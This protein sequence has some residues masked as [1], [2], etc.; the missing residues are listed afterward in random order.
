MGREDVGRCMNASALAALTSAVVECEYDRSFMRI[1]ACALFCACIMLAMLLP[2]L[3]RRWTRASSRGRFRGLSMC[4]AGWLGPAE[5]GGRGCQRT[6]ISCHG[7][8]GEGG[9]YRAD[10]DGLREGAMGDV[11]GGGIIAASLWAGEVGYGSTRMG[12]SLEDEGRRSAN[13]D[14]DAVG[15]ADKVMGDRGASMC[16][17]TG[18][19]PFAHPLPVLMDASSSLDCRADIFCPSA[20][21]YATPAIARDLAEGQELTCSISIR[22]MKPSTSSGPCPFA[23]TTST[24]CSCE[25]PIRCNC[26]G[27]LELGSDP[28]G[29]VLAGSDMSAEEGVLSR[30]ERGRDR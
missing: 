17:S 5:G 10:A 9:S 18:C 28:D 2:E 4:A 25:E 1:C 16:V 22:L 20:L 13:E 15:G 24:P 8:E 23:M 26:I 11:A 27:W 14:A 3:A 7:R 19:M 30:D 12:G 6:S 21:I 29:I